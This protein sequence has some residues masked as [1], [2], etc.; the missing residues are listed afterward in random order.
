MNPTTVLVGI[1]AV[2]NG[3]YTAWVRNARPEQFKKLQPMKEFWGARR[4]VV[5]HTIGYTVIPI[6]FGLAMIVSA[7][8]GGSLY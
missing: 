3:V 2:G 5:I 6:L 8:A 1:A 4:G 7:F